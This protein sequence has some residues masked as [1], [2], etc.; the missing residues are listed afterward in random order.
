MGALS[1]FLQ[2][3]FQNIAIRFPDHETGDTDVATGSIVSH[4]DVL[5]IL[6]VVIV[7]YNDS[8]CSYVLG[9]SDF[10]DEWAFST[11]DKDNR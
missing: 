4:N 1:I 11:F 5:D 8:L 6:S 2:E 3:L 9:M 7:N 10:Y